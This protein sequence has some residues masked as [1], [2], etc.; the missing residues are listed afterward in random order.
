MRSLNTRQLTGVLYSMVHT[1]DNLSSTYMAT[2]EFVRREQ[3]TLL[4]G[5]H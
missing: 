2:Q 4:L 3:R 5:L 1:F